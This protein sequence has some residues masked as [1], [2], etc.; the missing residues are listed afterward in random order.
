MLL[1]FIQ[2]KDEDSK[3]A[4]NK[5]SEMRRLHQ[6]Q[7]IIRCNKYEHYARNCPTR[8]KGRQYAS[9]IDIHPD[10]PQKDEDKRDE[11]YFL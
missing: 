9:T 11:N 10:P 2:R 8:K 1:H 6:R 7:A 4:S 3:E 5:H